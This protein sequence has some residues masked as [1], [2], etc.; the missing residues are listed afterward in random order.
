MIAI[1]FTSLGFLAW[2]PPLWAAIKAPDRRLSK[3]LYQVSGLCGVLVVASFVCI[4]FA[5]VDEAGTSTGPLVGLFAAFWLAAIALG[6]VVAIKYRN[7]GIE[8]GRRRH[9]LTGTP[10]AGAALAAR[11]AREHYR[12]LAL[13]DPALAREMALGRPDRQRQYDDG[14]LLDLN[15]LDRNALMHFARLGATEADAVIAYRE[16]CGRLTS[17]D[18]L[19]V[20]AGVDPPT[21]DMLREYAVFL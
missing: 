13:Q 2:V 4:G 7:I 21:T 18:E 14:G 1:P 3:R 19:V 17:V 15:A 9:M 12:Q 16:R 11:K 20:H 10:G 5:P 8:A 6:T